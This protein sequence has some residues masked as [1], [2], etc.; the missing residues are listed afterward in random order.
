MLRIKIE[1]ILLASTGLLRTRVRVESGSPAASWLYKMT[2]V[3]N[4]QSDPDNAQYLILEVL[5]T[6]LDLQRFKKFLRQK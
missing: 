1:E 5:A 6:S 4:A 2:T 3:M